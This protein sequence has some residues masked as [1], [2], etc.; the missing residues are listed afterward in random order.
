M[1]P[2]SDRYATAATGGT[3]YRPST[4][5]DDTVIFSPCRALTE[6]LEST[7]EKCLDQRL[8]AIGLSARLRCDASFQPLKNVYED[9]QPNPDRIDKV[10]VPGS[11]LK[12]KMIFR[13]KVAEKA[14]D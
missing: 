1:N 6:S 14:S 8:D 9:K 2:G 10:P 5:G 12:G 13:L 3:A 11:G 4:D 7:I